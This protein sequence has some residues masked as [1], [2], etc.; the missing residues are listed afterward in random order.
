MW[1]KGP[2]WK[3]GKRNIRNYPWIGHEGVWTYFHA[4]RNCMILSRKLARFA[5]PVTANLH[6]CCYNSSTP[7]LE[8]FQS[9]TTSFITLQ[10]QVTEVG[11]RLETLNPIWSGGGN[12]WTQCPAELDSSWFC[13]HPLRTICHCV[14]GS[15]YLSIEIHISPLWNALTS[16][17]KIHELNI[18][19]A[20]PHRILAENWNSYPCFNYPILH[21][22]K[23][24]SKKKYSCS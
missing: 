2:S 10:Q 11:N 21:S 18:I 24:K 8:Q 15:P 4:Q 22:D 12:L 17:V 16:T 23:Q 9:T 20:E 14:S 1:S 6:A 3:G 5:A 13:Y 19:M 7:S